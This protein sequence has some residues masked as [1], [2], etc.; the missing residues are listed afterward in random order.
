MSLLA[1]DVGNTNI[2]TGLFFDGEMEGA[3][4]IPVSSEPKQFW[5]EVEC[6]LGKARFKEITTVAISSVVREMD[7]NLADSLAEFYSMNYSGEVPKVSL[8]T[9]DTRWPLVSAYKPGLGTDRMLAAIAAA[10]LHGQPV[11]TIDIGSAVTVDFVDSEG[12]FRGGIILAGAGMRLRALAQFTSALPEIPIPDKPPLLIGTDTIGCMTS[13]VHH[14]MR[15]EIQGLVL[16][17]QAEIGKEPSVV[18]TGQGS[19]LF[20]KDRPVGWW[21]EEW[22]VLKGIYFVASEGDDRND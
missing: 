15:Q 11:V 1:I 20:R 10:K 14:G 12:V 22:L 6:K 18:L 13:G 4:K 9:K 21:I 2:S 19:Q 8:I 7:L 17:I 5:P 16:A 3:F